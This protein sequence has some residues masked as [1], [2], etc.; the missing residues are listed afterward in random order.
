MKLAV[1]DSISFGVG[2][3]AFDALE[4]AVANGF[5][6][7]Q[8]YLN[9][10]LIVDQQKLFLLADKTHDAQ[11]KIICHGPIPLNAVR[12][13][14]NLIDAVRILF[15]SQK[16]PA[17][18]LHHD[19]LC[20]VDIAIDAMR[21]WQA[22]GISIQLENFYPKVCDPEQAISSY[23]S[24]LTKAKSAGI[25]VTPVLDIPRLF[26]R[27]IA[28]KYSSINL[29]KQIMEGLAS[30]NQTIILHMIDC[31]TPDQDR[32]SWR[33]IGQGAIPYKEIFEMIDNAGIEIS[34]A[35]LEY[36]D[37]QSALDSISYFERLKKNSEHK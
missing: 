22:A 9:D 37:R 19:P 13:S 1:A 5:E 29:I 6:A 27:W 3:D 10:G 36:E 32:P 16:D 7:I 21:V 15:P 26:I 28:E 4:F 11:I 31:A 20:A 25:K 12:P 14:Q 33:P 23:I 17:I 35:V 18:L 2:K 8:Y 30:V 24:L 34:T